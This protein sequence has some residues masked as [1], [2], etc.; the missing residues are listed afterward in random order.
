MDAA[1]LALWLVIVSAYAGYSLWARL[2]PRYLLGAALLMVIAAAVLEALGDVA[3]AN[4]LAVD[5]F[6]AF[7]AGLVVL[8]LDRAISERRAT[9]NLGRAAGPAEP[10]GEPTDPR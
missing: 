9:R 10:A 3:A 2:D 4:A 5:T 7:L 1:F 6:F 8:V